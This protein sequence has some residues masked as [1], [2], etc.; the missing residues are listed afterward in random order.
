MPIPRRGYWPRKDSVDGGDAEICYNLN[1]KRGYGL[2]VDAKDQQ[3]KTRWKHSGLVPHP[4]NEL[5]FF[6]SVATAQASLTPGEL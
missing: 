5:E 3:A 2:F 4:S 1:V 6:L